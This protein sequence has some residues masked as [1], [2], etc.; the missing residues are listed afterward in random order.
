MRLEWGEGRRGWP[1]SWPGEAQ[2]FSEV[3]EG[4]WGQAP[5]NS[6]SMLLLSPGHVWVCTL[7]TPLRGGGGVGTGR[8]TV[9]LLLLCFLPFCWK[10]L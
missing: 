5:E 8:R 4:A 3:K 7:H 1:R 10:L 2:R 9:I 6:D